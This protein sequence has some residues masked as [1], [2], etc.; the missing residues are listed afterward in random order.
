VRV[1][2]GVRLSDRQSIVFVGP[3]FPMWQEIVLL[4]RNEPQRG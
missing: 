1:R 3:G 2:H 4:N